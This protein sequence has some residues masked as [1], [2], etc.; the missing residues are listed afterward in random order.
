MYFI[1]EIRKYLC[2]PQLQQNRTK[3]EEEEEETSKQWQT[4]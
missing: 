2:I 4:K 3:E 1:D